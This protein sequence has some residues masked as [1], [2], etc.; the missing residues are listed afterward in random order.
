[1]AWSCGASTKPRWSVAA[2][3]WVWRCRLRRAI[4]CL[5]PRAI[6]C[7]EAV[8][9]R[10]S[11][12]PCATSASSPGSSTV[13]SSTIGRSGLA[14]AMAA[15]GAPS[16]PATTTTASAADDSSAA[17]SYGESAVMTRMEG[18]PQEGEGIDR[19]GPEL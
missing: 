10:T 3:A 2:A 19:S 14:A 13:A 15:S 4:A 6:S 17:A 18:V 16:R 8:S 9:G 12:A 11:S 7:I 1:M 5:T